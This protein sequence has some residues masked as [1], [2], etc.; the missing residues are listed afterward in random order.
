M[1]MSDEFQPM[2][3]GGQLRPDLAAIAA[4][5]LPGSRVLDVGCEDGALLE[6]L[7]H[8]RGVIARGIELSQKGVNACVA[9]GLSVVQGDADRDLSNYPDR[10]FDTVILSQTL[11]ATRKPA[12]VLENLVRIGKRALVSIPNFGHWRVRLS[13]AVGGRMPNTA[14]LPNPWYNTPNIHLCTLKDFRMLCEE[15]GV[16]IERSIALDAEGRSMRLPHPA[17]ANLLAHQALFVLCRR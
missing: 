13:L 16:T 15:V 3:G 14:A 7:Q 12:P 2:S 1:N 17:L 8:E 6:H 11:Q 5:I 10:S 9:R 4:L